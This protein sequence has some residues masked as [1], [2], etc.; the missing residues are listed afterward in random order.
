MPKQLIL[1]SASPRRAELLVR[2]QWPFRIEP[3]AD[4][5]LIDLP[6]ATLVRRLALDKAHYV[7]SLHPDEDIVVLGADTVVVHSNIV[8]GKPTDVPHAFQMLHTLQG[9]LHEV[10]TGVAL[11]ND[12]HSTTC[13]E[14]TSVRMAPM[15]NEEIE[16]YIATGEPMDKAGSYGIQGI[17]SQ[18]IEGVRGCYYNVMGLP[19]HK[20]VS[21]YRQFTGDMVPAP[22]D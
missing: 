1:A 12:G 3:A 21:L 2:I 9:S 19:I 4:E 18:W 8:L 20:M 13:V 5:Q 16:A 14:R 11:V 22:W 7:A 17:G 10:Y 6:A 15:T